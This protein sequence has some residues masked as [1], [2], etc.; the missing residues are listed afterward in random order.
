MANSDGFSQEE[1]VSILFK[2]YMGFPSLKFSSDF[3]QETQILNNTNFLGAD[4]MTDTPTKNPN[5]TVLNNDS[6][7]RTK[8][9]NKLISNSS[10][11]VIAHLIG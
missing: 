10:N 6:T 8:V 4:I 5:Y 3:Y 9:L 1:I 11:L 7:D 2:N